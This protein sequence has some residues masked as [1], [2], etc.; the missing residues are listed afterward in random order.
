MSLLMT[1]FFENGFSETYFPNIDNR[2]FPIAIRPFVSGLKEELVLNVQVWDG[3]W[4]LGGSPQYSLILKGDPV[5]SAD[6]EDGTVIEGMVT[7]TDLYFSVKIDQVQ[8][9]NVN[10]GK[11]MLKEGSIFKLEIGSDDLC[12]IVYKNRFV[13][14]SHAEITFESGA[15]YITDKDSVNGTFLNGRMVKEKTRL[16]YGDI[17]YV[18]GL[19]IVYLNNLLAIN[20]PDGQCKI[21][22]LKAVEIPRFEEE[23][24]EEAEAENVY[25]LR[26]P[27]KMLNLDRETISIEKCPKKQQQKRQPLIFTIGPSFTMV[28]PI[29]LAAAMTSDGFGAGSICMSLGAAGIGAVW[30]VVNSAYNKKEEKE[31]E[32]NRVSKYLE[33]MVRVEEK[34]KNKAE[35]NHLVLAEQYPSSGELLKFTT[36]NTRRLWEKS[37]THEDF[38]SLRLGTGDRPSPNEIEGVKEELGGEHDPLNDQ[39]EELQEKF[40]TLHQVPVAVSLYEYRLLGVVS[41]EEEKRNQLMRL[42]S[43]QIAALHPYTD[44]RMCYVFPGRD[45]ETM[46]YVRWLPHTFTPDG[47]LRMIV[48]ESR[49]MGDVM[50]Y[51]SDVIRERLEASENQKNRE[52]NEK[53]LPHYVIFI[54][55]ISMIEGEPISKYLFD[56]PKNAGIS[57]VFSADAIDKLPSHCNTIVQWEEDYQSCY[58]TLSKFEEQSGISFDG[59]TLSEMDAFSRQL[60]N[61]KVRENASNAA[62]PDM[63]TFLDMYKTSKVEELDMYHKWLENRTYESMRSMIGQKAGEQPVYLDIHEKYHGPHGLVAGTTGSGKSETLQTY[64]L[65]LV[66]N[67][68]PHEV[69]FILIDYKGGGMAQS[70][71]GLP[72]LA[73]VITN[74]GGNQTTRALLSIN[75]EIKRRQR[76]FNEYKIKHIDAYIELYRNGEAEEPM[77]HLLIIADEFAELKKEQPD[78]VRALVSAARVGRSLGINLILATQKPSGVVDDEIWSNTRFRVCLRVADKQDSN[79]MLKRTDAAYITGTGRGFLQVGNDEIFDEFQSGWSGAPYT[80]EIPFSDDSKAKAVI[81]GLTGKPEAVKKKKKKKGDNVKKFTQLDAMVQYAAKLAEENH[82]KPLRQIWLAPLPGILYLDDLEFSWNEKQMQIPIGLADDPQN[83]RQFPV[84][85]DF[86]KDGHLLICGSAGAGK[87]TLVQTI[88]YGAAFHYTAKQINFYIADFS[89]RTMTAF[90]GLPHTGCICMEGDDE[91]IQMMMS[92]AEEELD[93]R[94]KLFSQRGMGSYRDYRE[95]Y[96]DVPAV[97]LV[98]DNY[99]AFSDSYEQ[100]ESTLIQLSREGASYGM[101]LILTCNNSGDIRSRI[102][103]NITKGIGLQLADRF[104][105]DSV[106]G[107]RSEI[108]PDDRTTGRGLIKEGVPLEFQAALPVKASQGE[109]M[110]LAVREKLKPLTQ[111]STSG[112][113]KLGTDLETIDGQEFLEQEDFKTLEDS[114]FVMGAEDGRMQTCD[115]DRTLCFTVCGSGKTGKTSFLK[116]TALQMKK[117]GADVYVFDGCLREMEEFSRTNDLDGYMADKE[118]LFHF[119]ESILLPQLAERNELVYEARQAGTSVKAALNNHKR[120]LLLINSASEFMEAVYSEDF[121]V[122]EVLETVFEKG[123]EHKLHFFM[124][125]SPREYEELSGYRAIRQFAGWKQGIHLGGAF[126]EQGI[127]EYE[128]TPSERSR[129]YPP[130]AAFAEQDGKA[131]LFMTPLIKEE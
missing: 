49:A 113:K 102:L 123:M 47:K 40:K 10:F 122:S 120:T 42:L 35:Y 72:H 1:V 20:N 97:F 27:R 51:L 100:Y 26:T 67:Y 15:A 60:S 57:V 55:D 75:A 48:C 4:T 53:V 93:R 18:V 16:H 101:Y 71:I 76:I 2:N 115:L 61:F 65:S 12:N 63:L 124:A 86:I 88:L 94:K 34:L 59:I 98:I 121:D 5:E 43:L 56:P 62:I 96:E 66:L 44:V 80:P 46:E 106:I 119:M 50:Y 105:Y 104:E 7:K 23:S 19:K 52:E 110:M 17:I 30:A 22:E 3:H 64:I 112:A 68:H 21:R 109:S 29:A 116:Y 39:M 11:Y 58:S 126:D 99:P 28:I 111:Q 117:K 90:A 14:G 91:K 13:T 128:L 54:S 130:G 77:P 129:V 25:F 82:I 73:G 31:S 36:S 8:K 85:L 70:F 69:A 125:L 108:L 45:L 6:L 37:S 74:L 84:C 32:S 89:S 83:Q 118:E 9:E 103:Q 24:T 114:V 92:F 131:V 87:T 107:M 79:E 81:I 38:L 127:F 41:K 95:S 33:Y 78:F